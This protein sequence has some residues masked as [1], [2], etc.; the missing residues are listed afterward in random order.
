M[1]ALS[2]CAGWCWRC[3]R[4][5][6]RR[7]VQATACGLAPR[8]SFTY[9]AGLSG[10]SRSRTALFSAVRSM[11]NGLLAVAGIIPSSNSRRNAR[12]A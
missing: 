8:G 5:A 1:L 6:T 4:S 12:L 11:E 2:R 10:I 7:F 9:R 3:G